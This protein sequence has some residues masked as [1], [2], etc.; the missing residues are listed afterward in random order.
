MFELLAFLFDY[1]RLS[2][3]AP[4]RESIHHAL[5]QADF[6][7]QEIRHALLCLD[8]LFSQENNIE[9]R[10]QHDQYAIRIFNHQEQ[11]ILPGAVQGL[12]HVLSQT[13]SLNGG[14][15]EFL[16]R[17]LMCLPNEDVTINNTKLL[18]LLLHLSQ[19]NTPFPASEELLSVL[20]KPQAIH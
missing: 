8:T 1:I 15:R 17:A 5:V 2:D 14:D 13:G 19:N 9:I 11:M 3:E 4:T 12:L 10:E 6:D 16:I 7:Y 20:P 18:I